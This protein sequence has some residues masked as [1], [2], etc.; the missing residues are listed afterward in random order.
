[1]LTL[2]LVIFAHVQIALG[3]IYIERAEIETNPKYATMKANFMH[4]L[5]GNSITNVTFTSYIRVTKLLI[6][7][8][9]KLAESADDKEFRR[10]LVSSVVDANKVFSGQQSSGIIS[11]Y[12]NVFKK[13]ADPRF[14]VPL[15]PV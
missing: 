11:R 4:D 2:L 12:F 13:S 1:M 14:K 7:F 15:P 9:I 6:Y 10:Q 3:T 5:E 8:K